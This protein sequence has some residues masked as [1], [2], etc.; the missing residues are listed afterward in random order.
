MTRYGQINLYGIRVAF[1]MCLLAVI[2]NLTLD[3]P[4]Y[5]GAIING[6]ICVLCLNAKQIATEFYGTSNINFI[7]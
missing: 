4:N 3:T 5:F 2:Y 1:V 6:F 7:Y